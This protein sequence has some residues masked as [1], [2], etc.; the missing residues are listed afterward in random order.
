MIGLAPL[1]LGDH[2]SD[3]LRGM[4]VAHDILEH[5]PK[6]QVEWQGLGGAVYVRGLTG[7]FESRPFNPSPIENIAGEFYTLFGLWEGGE[8]PTPGRAI[9]RPLR[10][11][12]AEAMIQDIVT[13]GCRQTVAECAYSSDEES[14]LR[15]EGWTDPANFQRM[16]EW[17]RLGYRACRQR[18]RPVPAWRLRATFEAIESRIDR[19]LDRQGA[20]DFEGGE[21]I[22][23]FDP[24]TSDVTVTVGFR[25]EGYESV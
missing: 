18:W 10:G 14:R 9:V 4:G 12:D 24:Y 16:V 15:A 21:C 11:E 1:W 13:E 17:M 22:I 2:Q 20:A 8:I 6:D 5:G 19:L 7:Y 25:G 23:R 3:P